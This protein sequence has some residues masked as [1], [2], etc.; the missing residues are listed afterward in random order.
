MNISWVISLLTHEPLETI[1]QG[2]YNLSGHIHPAV[3]LRGTGS[4]VSNL[5]VFLFWKT[6]GYSSGIWFVYR[7]GPD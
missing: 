1:P 6:A 2:V 7:N 4:A 5:A 3:Q